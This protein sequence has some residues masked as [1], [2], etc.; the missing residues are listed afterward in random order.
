MLTLPVCW[1][2]TFLPVQ[3]NVLAFGSTLNFT[4]AGVVNDKSVTTAKA[5]SAV[6][7]IW[8]FLIIIKFLG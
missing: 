6:R 3:T 8:A 5:T 7:S 2:V 4:G 1:P